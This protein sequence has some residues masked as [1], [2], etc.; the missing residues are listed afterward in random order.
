MAPTSTP[1]NEK[2]IQAFFLAENT[3]LDLMQLYWNS[4]KE[5]VVIDPHD[6][7]GYSSDDIGGGVSLFQVRTS[8]VPVPAAIWLFGTALIGLVGFG[9]RSKST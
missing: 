3:G 5:L 1:P 9:R 8:V 6:Y 7:R 2:R 4:E